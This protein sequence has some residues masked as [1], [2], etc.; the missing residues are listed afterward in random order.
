MVASCGARES[1][2]SILDC[3]AMSSRIPDSATKGFADAASY[4]KHR[5]SY[6]LEV[7]DD[8]LAKLQVK[9]INN[10][11]IVDVGAGTGK[12]TE[13]LA[14][15]D[16][17]YT[18]IAVEPHEEMRVQCVAKKLKGVKIVDGA[19]NNMPLPT[20]SADAV[21]VAQVR[22]RTPQLQRTA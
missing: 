2:I 3:P 16:E 6:P 15:R 14:A 18:I 17:E 5:P 4:E 9:G 8:L 12:F 19:G 1:V 20:Q 13:M 11:C 10:A 22:L 21:V 7:V